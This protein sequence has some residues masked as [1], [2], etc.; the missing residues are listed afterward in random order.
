MA[1]FLGHLKT[2]RQAFNLRLGLSCALIAFSQVN[3]GFDQ[4][5]FSTT[6]AMDS[7]GRKFGVYNPVTDEWALD[8]VYLSIFNALP[9][10]GFFSGKDELLAAFSSS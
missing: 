2:V 4:V 8:P 9:Y 6:Q 10:L 3:F 1:G 5:A 7:F